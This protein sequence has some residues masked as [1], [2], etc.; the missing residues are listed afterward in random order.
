[1]NIV[2]SDDEEDEF[3]HDDS[4]KSQKS[5]SSQRTYFKSWGDQLRRAA[6]S[7]DGRFYS[8]DGTLTIDTTMDSAMFSLLFG[9][10]GEKYKPALSKKSNSTKT[11]IEFAFWHRVKDLFASHGV[12]LNKEIQVPVVLDHRGGIYKG[13]TTAALQKVK[14][15][16]RSLVVEY[17]SVSHKLKLSF[18]AKIDYFSLSNL[19]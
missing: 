13:K 1:M 12:T 3:D 16:I 18:D 5:S 7:K 14:A 2:R 9:G 4:P 15:E 17:S 6:K 11:I 10:K 8:Q 19:S